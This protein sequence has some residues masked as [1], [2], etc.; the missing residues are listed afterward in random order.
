MRDGIPERITQNGE[1]PVTHIASE[2]EYNEKLKEKLQEEVGEWLE[3]E[4]AEEMADVFEV[5]TA[6]LAQKNWTIEQIIDIQNKKRQE[7]GGFTQKI[8]LETVKK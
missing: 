8:I 3:V 1:I 7:R 6:I 5:I 4:S 2:K